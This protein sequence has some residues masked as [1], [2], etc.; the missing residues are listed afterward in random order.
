MCVCVS[1]RADFNQISSDF[2]QIFSQTSRFLHLGVDQTRWFMGAFVFFHRG[3]FFCFFPNVS[4]LSHD[5]HVETWRCQSHTVNT[6]AASEHTAKNLSP[7]LHVDVH[8]IV[9]LIFA[10]WKKSDLIPHDV[11]KTLNVIGYIT[12]GPK[13]PHIAGW[14][15]WCWACTRTCDLCHV[16]RLQ[17]HWPPPHYCD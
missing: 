14:T 7:Y 3:I 4:P 13:R 1:V 6:S 8:I 12:S 2:N 15:R 11:I 17:G 5:P 9:G 10:D 16:C